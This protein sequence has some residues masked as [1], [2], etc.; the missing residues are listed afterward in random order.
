[1]SELKVGTQIVYVPSHANGNINHQ[2]C[3]AGF[4]MNIT[5]YFSENARYF[6]RYWSKFERHRLRTISTS[7]LTPV[8]CLV[9]KKTRDQKII[10]KLV[11]LLRDGY[12]EHIPREQKGKYMDALIKGEKYGRI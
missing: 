1:M 3:E 5:D 9:V 4:I 8:T 12:P 7:E 6:C 11:K 2:D 10:D